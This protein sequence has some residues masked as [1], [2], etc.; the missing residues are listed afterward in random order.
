MATIIIKNNTD[1]NVTIEDLGIT[2]A[3][4]SQRTL[5]DLFTLVEISDS[6]DLVTYVNNETF[7]VNNGV[8][9]LHRINGLKHI[10][11]ET[12][13]E[14]DV[15]EDVPFDDTTTQPADDFFTITIDADKVIG[16]NHS[17]FPVLIKT[18]QSFLKHTNYGGGVSNTNG[19]DIIFKDSLGT[20]LDHEMEKYDPETG[21]VIAWVRIPTLSYTED[22]VFYGYFGSDATASSEDV[23]GV[24]DSVY[25]AVWHLDESGDGTSDEYED[26]SGNGN[27]GQGGA[28]AGASTPTR[29]SD[30]KISYGQSFDGGDFITMGNTLSHGWGSTVS[31]SAWIKTSS[32]NVSIMSKA[33]DATDRGEWVFINGSGQFHYYLISLFIIVYYEKSKYSSATVNNNEWHLLTVTYSG[34]SN[35]SGMNLYMDG[36]LMAVG[37]TVNETTS[38]TVENTRPF[39]IGS[40]D[41]GGGYSFT[42]LIDECRVSET[43]LSAGWIETEFNNQSSPGTFYSIDYNGEVVN[44][45]ILQLVDYVGDTSINNTSPV[46]IPLSGTVYFNSTEFTITDNTKIGVINAGFYKVSYAVNWYITSAGD[47]NIR[48]RIRKNGDTYIEPSTSYGY[49]INPNH[50]EGSNTSNILIYLTS[51]DYIEIMCDRVGNTT[52]TLTEAGASHLYMELIS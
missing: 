41:D 8:E 14:D 39:N 10:N 48:T 47:A 49:G 29:T 15:Y 33:N 25:S 51:E 9:D 37:G 45:N 24:W 16:S 19:Y 26:S 13:Y 3:A 17:N 7:T 27:H 46:A 36:Q 38:G 44:M 30:G 31:H 43:V 4:S 6:E 5:S 11:L 28:G 12:V 52:E 1:S 40:S 35:P 34:N 23:S 2:I 50:S 21:E 32:S 22:T 42:G 20:Q 18:I